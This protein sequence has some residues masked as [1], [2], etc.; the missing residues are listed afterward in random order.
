MAMHVDA[1]RVFTWMRRY[2]FI[3]RIESMVRG[4]AQTCSTSFPIYFYKAAVLRF[5][6]DDLWFPRSIITDRSDLLVA[7]YIGDSWYWEPFWIM[8]IILYL[9]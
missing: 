7:S 5:I 9:S 4:K 3:W 2:K 6:L 1:I 8:Y